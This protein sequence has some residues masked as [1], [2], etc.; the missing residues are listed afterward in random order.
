MEIEEKEIKQNNLIEFKNK[1]RDL[2]PNNR[3]RN[4]PFN[5]NELFSNANFN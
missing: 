5:M 3:P 2:R 4:E 1:F